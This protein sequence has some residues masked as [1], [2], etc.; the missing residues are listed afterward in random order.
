M[1]P[2]QRASSNQYVLLSQSMRILLIAD[3]MIP[4]PPIHYGGVER[5]VDMLIDQYVDRRHEV[6]L[7]GH[8]ESRPE[9]PVVPLPGMDVSGRLD[10]LWNTLLVRRVVKRFRPDVVHSFGRLAY[11]TSIMRMRVPKLM[12]YGRNPALSQIGKAMRLARKDSLSFAGCAEHIA[13]KI[14]PIAPTEVVFNGVPHAIYTFKET[15]APDAPLVF[16]GRIEPDRKSVV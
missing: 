15:V 8:P 14:R 2:R 7:V 3:P 4:V 5:L 1:R 11:M 9:C 10:T 13:A 12:S 6:M 16:L